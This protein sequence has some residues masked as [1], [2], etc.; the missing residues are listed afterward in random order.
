MADFE[1][2]RTIYADPSMFHRTSQQSEKPGHAPEIA[3]SYNELYSELGISNLCP[4]SGDR[5]DVSFAGRLMQHWAD[6]DNR[7]PTV[8]ILCRRGL[9]AEKP[10]PGLHD[11]GCP[12]LLWELRNTRRV[13]LTSQQLLYRNASE[14]IVDKDNHA[15]DAMKYH[16]MSHPEP[17]QKSSARR[18]EECV[19]ELMKSDPTQ[20][21]MLLFR[22]KEEQRQVEEPVQFLYS[23][24]ARQVLREIGRRSRF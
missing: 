14:E 22:S 7:E 15:R 23:R 19:G 2:M 13:K 24:N 20:A 5:S 10:D 8:K 9:Y 1:C 3:K 11:W 16:L 18:L 12:N 4:F 21:M 17:A 6:L